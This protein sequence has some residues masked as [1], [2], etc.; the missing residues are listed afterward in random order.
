MP[1]WLLP[2]EQ[3]D[4]SAQVDEPKV[5]EMPA[6]RMQAKMGRDFDTADRLR[7]ELRAMGVE[8]YD[9]EK[10]WKAGGGG[11]FG[12]GGGGRGGGGGGT[13]SGNF[14]EESKPL[15]CCS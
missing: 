14:T 15:S 9:K 3:D 10:T 4:G 2:V 8:V 12:G 5:H 11:G 6:R 1:A 7:D 13:Y